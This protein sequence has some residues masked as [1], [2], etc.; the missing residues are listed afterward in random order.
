MAGD[1][2]FGLFYSCTDI[3]E[4]VRLSFPPGIFRGARCNTAMGTFS[5]MRLMGTE[6]KSAWDKLET[7]LFCIVF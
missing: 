3:P 6:E 7:Y 4:I 2:G 5:A 1:V